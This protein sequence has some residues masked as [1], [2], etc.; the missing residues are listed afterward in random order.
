MYKMPGDDTLEKLFNR[1]HEDGV[2]IAISNY[3]AK[4]NDATYATMKTA[5]DT[6]VTTA[7]SAGGFP[8]T[9]ISPAIPTVANAR[10]VVMSA[11]SN[12]KYDSKDDTKNT[13]LNASTNV[14]SDNH[15]S[16]TAVATAA[17]SAAGQGH[18]QK[19][20]SSTGLFEHYLAKRLGPD[21]TEVRGI[22]RVSR[23]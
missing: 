5:C 3:I 20:S 6:F 12:V 11:D 23:T 22:T 19:R 21:S 4:P 2:G 1:H 9:S 8:A 14:V 18:E 16:R 15:F 13:A 7:K 10:L 17:L